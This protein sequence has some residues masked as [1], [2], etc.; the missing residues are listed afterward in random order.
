M[1]AYSKKDNEKNKKYYEL[2]ENNIK[3][4]ILFGIDNYLTPKDEENKNKIRDDF[5][6]LKMNNKNI[7]INQMK[8]EKKPETLITIRNKKQNNINNIQNINNNNFI[9]KDNNISYNYDNNNP[10]NFINN[11]NKNNTNHL[12]K[13][14]NNI[15]IDNNNK[16]KKDVEHI[17]KNSFDKTFNKKI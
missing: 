14:I 1:K 2:F 16:L 9:N 17:I 8:D 5:K 3:S 10:N 6:I 15:N 12:N 13:N 11:D 7:D 4:V